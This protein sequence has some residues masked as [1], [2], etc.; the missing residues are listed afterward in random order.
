MH[1]TIKK[2]SIIPRIDGI[3]KDIG[4]LRKLGQISISDF[5]QDE[6]K[7]DL[8]KYYLRDAL[9]GV[10]HIASHILSRIPGSRATEYKELALKLGEAGIVP[11]DF[12][13]SSLKEMAGYRNRLTHFYAQITSTEIYK[14]IQ[15]DLDDIDIFLD[16]I[17][18][19]LKDSEKF[20]L[21]LE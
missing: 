5:K 12:T 21:T 16:H 4:K 17:K 6:E 15:E 13:E 11:Q 14:I 9:E 18:I 8:A 19:L 7:F 3:E 20:D 10:F 2:Q 1:K